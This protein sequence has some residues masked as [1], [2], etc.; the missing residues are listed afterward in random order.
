M[1][2]S[3]MYARFSSYAARRIIPSDTDLCSAVIVSTISFHSTTRTGFS[4][5][6]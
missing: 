6:K 1:K 2:M 5:V 4:E 3:G